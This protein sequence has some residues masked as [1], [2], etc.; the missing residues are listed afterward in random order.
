MKAVLLTDFLLFVISNKA[1][2][3]VKRSTKIFMKNG[4]NVDWLW[5]GL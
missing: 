1:I 4:M 2:E 5:W 3:Q